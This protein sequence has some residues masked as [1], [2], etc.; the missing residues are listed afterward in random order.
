MERSGVSGEDREVVFMVRDQRFIVQRSKLQV[1]PPCTCCVW[2]E[3]AR[4]RVFLVGW[5][6]AG[7][8]GVVAGQAG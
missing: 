4:S 8:P 3:L 2:H 6:G 5:V 7:L 1:Q